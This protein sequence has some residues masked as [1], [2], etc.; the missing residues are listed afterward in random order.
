MCFFISHSLVALVVCFGSL[1]CWKTQRGGRRFAS[2]ILQYM[3]SCA[4][5]STGT[6][7]AQQDFNPLRCSVLPMVFLV[8]V[9]PTSFISLTTLPSKVA[10]GWSATS[11]SL[12][13]SFTLFQLF[14]QPQ[15]LYTKTLT[16]QRSF[17]FASVIFNSK[18]IY[19][20]SLMTADSHIMPLKLWQISLPVCC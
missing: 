10:L 3:T 19:V 5:W 7:Q 14:R 16:V 11:L 15:Y 6:L 12:S 2:K 9:V 13:L 18:L 8:T 1:S 17:T 4:F 20:S